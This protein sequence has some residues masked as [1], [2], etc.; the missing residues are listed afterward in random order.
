MKANVR[1]TPLALLGAALLC[2][3]LTIGC[4]SNPAYRPPTAS[5]N[6][7]RPADASEALPLADDAQAIVPSGDR[8]VAD[9]PHVE[10][11]ASDAPSVAPLATAP[12]SDAPPTDEST[13]AAAESPPPPTADAHAPAA[14]ALKFASARPEYF[15]GWPKPRLALVISGRQDGYLEPCGCAGLENQK[16]GLNRRHAFF[17]QLAERGWPLAAVD[18]GGQVRRFGRQAEVQYTLVAD[19]LKQMGYSAVAFGADDLRLSAGH[20]LSSVV[21]G[22]PEDSIFV[23]ANVSLFGLTPKT[24]IIEAGGMKIGV[25]SIL[26]KSFQEQLNNDEIEVQPAADALRAALPALA[27]CDVRVLLAHATSAECAELAREFPE[28]MLVVTAEDVDEPKAQPDTIEGTH[29]RLIEVGHKGMYVVVAGFFNDPDEPIRFQRVALDDRY[30]DT[31][32]MKQLMVTY[33]DQLQQLGWDG[34]GIRSVPHPRSRQAGEQ[35]G[36]FVGSAKCQDCHQEAYDVWSKS[37]HAHA[38]DTLVHLDP[39]RQFDAECV[40]CHVVGWS[41]QDYFPFT[42]GYDSLDKTPHLVGNGCENCHGPG[43]AHVAAE[44]GEDV[45]VDAETLRKQMHLTWNSAKTDMC[46]KCH[47][48]DN[49]PEF[50]GN[51]DHY[52]SEIAH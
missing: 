27:E 9:A 33:Q 13:G 37:K 39:P 29:S 14:S 31:P 34:L 28:F 50:S 23:A 26:G 16:G 11:P 3:L 51:V 41:P 45:G 12:D 6:G 38:T 36:Q 1:H 4:D 42:S 18:V 7:N 35:G 40:S 32:E 52:W 46:V 20:L 8:P 43:G 44:E 10:T 48:L 47:D 2:G 22:E 24:K 21:T 15:V 19:A 49:S 17:K 30:P 5:V 25:T